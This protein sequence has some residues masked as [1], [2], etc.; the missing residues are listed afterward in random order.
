MKSSCV[1]LSVQPV[2]V[3]DMLQLTCFKAV[4]WAVYC[5]HIILL[6]PLAWQTKA[7]HGC[8]G[9]ARMEEA[10]ALFRNAD[11]T[12]FVIVTIPTAMAAAESMRLAKALLHEQVRACQCFGLPSHQRPTLRY[13]PAAPAALTFSAWPPPHVLRWGDSQV[14]AYKH[15]HL[16]ASAR[17]H[18]RFWLDGD[19]G[20]GRGV[21]GGSLRRM[22]GH[23][24]RRAWC[25]S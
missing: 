4:L 3:Q 7:T 12:Q 25:T 8:C 22:R 20:V 18:V 23:A 10:R 9:Q 1:L 14:C 15:V 5:M 11:A 13:M 6:A 17:V 19:S 21:H 2:S 16:H 24:Q